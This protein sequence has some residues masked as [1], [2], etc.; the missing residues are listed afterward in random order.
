MSEKRISGNSSLEEISIR[1]LGVI[2]SANI[3][4]SPGLT[5]LTGETGAGKT[6]VLTAVGL[7]LG[8]KSDGDLVR[9]GSERSIVSAK[10]SLLPDLAKSLSESGE[11][12]MENELIISRTVSAEGKS[13]INIGGALSTTTRAAELSQNLIEIHGQSNNARLLKNSVQRE[14]LDL[15]VKSSDELIRYQ[16]IF[17][18][19]KE[20]D[21]RIS[22]L[23]QQLSKADSEIA[24]L[25]VFGDAFS[26]V[27]PKPGEL[28]SIE[29][30]ISKLGS[31]EELHSTI[32][33]GLNLLEPEEQSVT[34]TLQAVRKLLEQSKDK[35]SSLTPLIDKYSELVLDLGDVV[36]ELLV[37]LNR[38]EAD[39]ERFEYLQE[40]KAAINSLIKKYGQGSDRTLALSELV[41][42]FENTKEKIT[43]LSGGERRIGELE[44]EQAEIFAKLRDAALELSAKRIAG[45]VQLSGQV[46]EEIR[47]LSMPKATLICEVKQRDSEKFS[48]YSVTGLDDVNFLFSG[49]SDAGALPLAK[50]A[51]GGEN[52]RVMLAIAVVLAHSSHIGT[53]IFD[54]VDAGVGGAA[55]VEVGRR[56]KALAKNAQ[57]I[58]V[59]HLAQVA[60]WADNHLVVQKDQTGSISA[61]G[62][63]SLRSEDRKVEIARMLSG[64]SQSLTA[65]EHA[66]ELLQLVQKSS[67][68]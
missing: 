42:R 53:Y 47:S 52:S 62:V 55:A 10:F 18:D 67:L 57:V 16:S 61:S 64:Q 7:V 40:R 11:D 23:R 6:M 26:K 30:E 31:V 2:E 66:A 21:L 3:E 54:E 24:A 29:Q 33:T 46:T 20:I 1:N 34:S 14:L 5:V 13:R 35:D 19:Y 59:T 12:V 36:S 4:F 60:V 27:M 44:K 51:S 50:V 45:A 39:P 56:L 65:Q 17:E 9:T 8:S 25:T 22:E 37:Y 41:D 63:R 49:H 28:E 15:F 43:D 38:L 32:T 48:D 58:V 68:A